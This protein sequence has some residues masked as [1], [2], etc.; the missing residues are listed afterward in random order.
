VLLEIALIIKN[1]SYVAI[2]ISEIVLGI[3]LKQSSNLLV[4]MF[5]SF[6]LSDEAANKYSEF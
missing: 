2:F 6:I 4:S 3:M 5:Q 1:F